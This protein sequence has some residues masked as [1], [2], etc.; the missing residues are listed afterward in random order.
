VVKLCDGRVNVILAEGIRMSRTPSTNK[1]RM[2]VV[3]INATPR[4]FWRRAGG[5]LV[6]GGTVLERPPAG[7]C[8]AI[9]GTGLAAGVPGAVRGVVAIRHLLVC[10]PVAF[11]H[12]A[13]PTNV[14]V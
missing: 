4:E 13:L 7:G 6:E 11:T 3:R 8:F 12:L 1:I 10:V 5:L 9:V 14:T 2:I